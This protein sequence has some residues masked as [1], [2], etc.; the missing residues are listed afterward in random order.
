MAFRTVEQYNDDKYRFKFVIQNDNESQDVIFLYQSHKDMLV[1]DV[2][3]VISGEYTGYVHCTG[4]GCPVCALKRDDGKDLIRKQ[5]KIFIPVYNIG[6]DT[7][8]FWDRSYNQGFVAQ[9]DRDV[10]SRYPNPSEYVFKIT[11]HGAYRSTDTRYDIRA[12]ANN[13]LISYEAILAKFNA[14]MPEYYENIVKS[15]S[16]SE[17]NEMLKSRGTDNSTVSQEYVPIP[18]AGYQSS[19]PNTFV[20]ASEALG[21]SSDTDETSDSDDPILS[22]F[23]DKDDDGELP[24]PVF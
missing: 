1:A 11:R 8:E 3:Y 6:K 7:I 22:K 20:N 10:F 23:D 19:I 17:L 13:T 12:V 21:G 16:V 4:D 15:A 2:H 18:R 24:D 5:T 14:T 9:L